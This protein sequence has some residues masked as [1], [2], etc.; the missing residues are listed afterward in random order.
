M[1][2]RTLQKLSKAALRYAATFPFNFA[3]ATTYKSHPVTA[4]GEDLARMHVKRAELGN[5]EIGVRK[6]SEPGRR[7]SWR[8]IL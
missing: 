8:D 6:S 2:G 1:H 5:S 4:D 7:V 3:H